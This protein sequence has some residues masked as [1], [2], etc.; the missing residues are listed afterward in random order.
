M[1][2][3][4]RLGRDGSRRALR[5]FGGGAYAE[6]LAFPPDSYRMMVLL[7]AALGVAIAL[8]FVRLSSSTEVH[9]STM[10]TNSAVS[11]KDFFSVG[12]SRPVVLKLASLFALDSFRKRFGLAPAVEKEL[13]RI[14]PRQM[15]RRL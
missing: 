9:G 2:H 13:L 7:Y 10:E 11:A 6:R 8:L 1:V 5:R 14:S 15:D 12:R 3:A 4:R